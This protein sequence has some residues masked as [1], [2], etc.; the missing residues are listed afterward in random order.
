MYAP[1]QAFQERW[2]EGFQGYAARLQ[3]LTD[4]VA[5]QCLTWEG[6]PICAAFFAISGGATASASHVWGQEVPY[7]QA[8]ASPGD[9]FAQG[10]LSTVHFT[11]E[12]LQA[13]A[14]AAW[15]ED[16]DF[17]GPAE[18][19]VTEIS[20]SPSEY[21]ASAQVGGKTVTGEELRE[22]FGLRSACFQLQVK[23]GVFQF[24]V[25]GW[26]H[27]VGMSQAGAAFLANQGFSYQEILAHYYPGTTLEGVA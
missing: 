15:G 4:A 16:L 18:T 9:A 20:A 23:D 19:W 6:Q 7:L 2:G 8:V 22:A 14:A 21:V 5:G 26:G 17:S 3:E 12:E 11:A 1:P 27:G 24:A 10:Y 25:H 13:A